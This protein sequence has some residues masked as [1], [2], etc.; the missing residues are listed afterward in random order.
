[1]TITL[2]SCIPRPA[3]LF[4]NP[5]DIE[6]TKTTEGLFLLYCKLFVLLGVYSSPS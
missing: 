4:K 3:C 6:T 5:K 1:M 2:S